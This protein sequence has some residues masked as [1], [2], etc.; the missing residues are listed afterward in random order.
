MQAQP[1]LSERCVSS[2]RERSRQES[3]TRRPAMTTP[4]PTS[5][6]VPEQNTPTPSIKL[7]FGA[8]ELA[9]L[10]GHFHALRMVPS[11]TYIRRSRR[12]AY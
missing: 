3:P 1:Q 9:N 7:D 11:T 5:T 6:P 12:G 4:A 10:R 2:P 8:E